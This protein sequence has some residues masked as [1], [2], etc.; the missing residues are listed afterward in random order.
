MRFT[1]KI[2]GPLL[3]ALVLIWQ[4]R[5]QSPTNLDDKVLLRK[6]WSLNFLIHSN[7]SWGLGFRKGDHKTYYDHKI[8]EL[9]LM[10]MKHPKEVKTQNAVFTSARRYVY[11]KLNAFYILHAGVGKQ[12]L[13]NTKPY[14]GGVEVKYI[15]TAGAS[16]GMTIPTYLY[17]ITS[18][19][20]F[21]N[22]QL[23]V[24]HYDP[25]RHFQDNIYG[26]GPIL[27][28]IWKTKFHPGAYAK[29]GLSF[30]FGSMDQTI[31]ALEMGGFVDGYLTDIPIMA[32]QTNQRIFTSLYLALHFGKRK[33]PY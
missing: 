12:H 9:E 27:K 4:A 23:D 28:G 25:E 29:A 3:F 32:L 30:E 8:W 7:N 26:N 1:I 16:I 6:E 11:G 13:L 21:G 5:A 19:D 17:I 33:N 31:W 18:V 15:L 10:G 24:E 14:W 20:N 22:Y 2:L